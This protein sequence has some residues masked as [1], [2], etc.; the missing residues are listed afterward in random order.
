M[1]RILRFL[2]IGFIFLTQLIGPLVH[3]HSGGAP[4]PGILHL[5]GLEHLAMPEGAH[6]ERQRGDVSRDVVVALS[7]ALEVAVDLATPQADPPFVALAGPLF[8]LPS[9]S[10]TVA[11]APSKPARLP[12]RGYPP[13]SPRAPPALG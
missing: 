3:A 12:V 11:A 1:I 6:A 2:I 7:P 5:P 9:R 8:P 4:S 13:S 10:L